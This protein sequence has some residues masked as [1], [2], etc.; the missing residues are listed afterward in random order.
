MCVFYAKV[1][2]QKNLICEGTLQIQALEEESCSLK[3]L[4]NEEQRQINLSKKQMSC[5]KPLEDECASLQ[6]QV[7]EML[8]IFLLCEGLEIQHVEF[9]ICQLHFSVLTCSS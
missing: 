8:N 7:L 3:M 9:N 5:K 2:V 6:I 4:I 1:N